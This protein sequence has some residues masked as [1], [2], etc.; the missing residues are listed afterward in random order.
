MKKTPA[1]MV[2]A[3]ISLLAFAQ[4]TGFKHYGHFMH[5]MH[6]GET[7]GQVPLSTLETSAG[8]YGVGALAGLKGELI[9]V[10][11]KLL[12]SLGANAQGQVQSPKPA[13]SAVLWASA[14]VTQWV[15]VKV[16][17][18]MNQAQIE[19]YVQAQAKGQK[20]DLGQPFVFRI[21]GDYTHLV[22]HVVTGEKS[23]TTGG[24]HGGHANHGG[25]HA[26][27][28]SG[29]KQFRNPQA[30]GQ[31]V[32]VYTGPKLEGVVSHE[33]ERFHVHYIDNAQTVSGHVDQ[34]SVRAGA[35]LWL[36]KI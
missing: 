19:S 24:G 36:P 1:F 6:T 4:P 26:N 23:A 22:W 31:L 14:K 18:D 7:A 15:P 34:Y 11:G 20:L 2:L 3:F 28:Q 8:V 30:Q 32:G 25:G 33:G 35:T 9:Q 5:M 27:Q 16:P 21:T 17:S 10:D 13:D 12:V 29:M